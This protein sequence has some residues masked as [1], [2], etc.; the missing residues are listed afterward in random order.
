[1]FARAIS[2]SLLALPLL[3]AAVALPGG[4][5]DNPPPALCAANTGSAQCCDS[6][7]QV[8]MSIETK[9]ILLINLTGFCPG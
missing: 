7:T 9:R 3:A 1:M 2:F 4:G 8:S 5:D 6:S